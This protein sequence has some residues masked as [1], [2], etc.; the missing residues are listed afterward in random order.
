MIVHVAPNV[1]ITNFIFQRV[2]NVYKI[3][4]EL[5]PFLVR[6]YLSV[7]K[8]IQISKRFVK[9]EILLWM[10]VDNLSN[11]V[12]FEIHRF[13]MD[14]VPAKVL[15]CFYQ[16]ITLVQFPMNCARKHITFW[17][18]VV[19]EDW[20]WSLFTRGCINILLHEDNCIIILW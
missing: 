8:V 14:V 6:G 17:E 3:S 19:E 9:Y 5:L 4:N 11:E 10:L 16:K 15:H 7:R 12:I 1:T 2:E 18:S 13:S 20:V